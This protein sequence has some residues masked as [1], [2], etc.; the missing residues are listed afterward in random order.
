MPVGHAP[1]EGRADQLSYSIGG[2]QDP[3]DQSPA[4]QFHGIERQEGNDHQQPH[5]VH[6]G[7]DHQDDELA[8]RAP[9]SRKGSE[10]PTAAGTGEESTHE[11]FRG[12]H[13]VHRLSQRAPSADIRTRALRIHQTAR[14]HRVATKPP[15]QAIGSFRQRPITFGLSWRSD[16]QKLPLNVIA[17]P[18][19]VFV[20]PAGGEEEFVAGLRISDL[21]GV[22][23]SL[24]RALH[25]RGVT[26]MAA[27]RAL[28]VA[29]MTGWWGRERAE[30]LWRRCRGIDGS[31]V[32]PD[33]ETRSVSS[34]TTFRRDVDNESALEQALLAQVVDASGSLRHK[35]LFARTVTVKLRYADF[36]VRSRSRTLESP[37]RTE[38]A[39]FNVARQLLRELRVLR[40]GPG[41]SDWSGPH[42]PRSAWR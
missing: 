30:W 27:L 19:G 2:N 15:T 28:D 31:P 9:R 41:A 23:P 14:P 37:V 18:N 32:E 33:R 21:I 36:S 6:E 3:D 13:E 35:D 26:T 4:T 5:H 22:G 20:V 12:Y 34:E 39:I 24:Q 25:Q 8:Q 38:R 11:R 16:I 10:E 7:R 29:T 42:Q 1:P 17:K 40:G